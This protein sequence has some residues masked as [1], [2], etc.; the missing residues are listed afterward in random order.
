MV[1][2]ILKKG[3]F[4]SASVGYIKGYNDKDTDALTLTSSTF[5]VVFGRA[6][7]MNLGLC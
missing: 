7:E 5:T 6:G 1:R 3:H 2:H 4:S